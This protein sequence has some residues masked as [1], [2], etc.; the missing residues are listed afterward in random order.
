MNYVADF[1]DSYVV[2]NSVRRKSA[3]AAELTDK[4]SSRPMPPKVMS[5]GIDIPKLTPLCD[6]D[7]LDRRGLE[8]LLE[9]ILAVGITGIFI[10]RH[11]AALKGSQAWVFRGPRKGILRVNAAPTIKFLHR[12]CIG[13]AI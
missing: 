2:W 9:Y 11:R 8:R 10:L 5:R 13:E 4:N 6:R 3:R 7:A 1:A 12:G